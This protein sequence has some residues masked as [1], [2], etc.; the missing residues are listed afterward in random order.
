MIG[1]WAREPGYR[2]AAKSLD[3]IRT[4][5]LATRAILKV[6]Q[7]NFDVVELLENELRRNGIHFHI[8]EA[9]RI[10]GEAAR[11]VPDEGRILITSESYEA[12]CNEE[13]D[14]QLLVPHE[15]AHIVLRHSATFARTTS[16]R[17]HTS[18]EDSE[19]QADRFSH[20]FAMP[21]VLVRKHCRSIGDIQQVFN[22]NLHE[23]QIRRDQ[24][25]R[26]QEINW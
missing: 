13:P 17:V 20:E 6:N 4:S 15:V 21:N 12:I 1:P 10:P 23:A 24:L 18:I 2:V 11:A 7:T 3:Q 5:A 25:R 9:E 8:V 14:F 19:V 16:T 26:E 22:V